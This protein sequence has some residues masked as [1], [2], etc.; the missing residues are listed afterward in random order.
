[1]KNKLFYI[2]FISFLGLQ[3]PTFAQSA[4]QTISIEPYEQYRYRNSQRGVKQDTYQTYKGDKNYVDCAFVNSE[5]KLV[6]KLL[7]SGRIYDYSKDIYGKY[8]VG[9]NMY[10]KCDKVYIRWDHGGETTGNL[11]YG[12]RSD[13]RPKFRIRVGSHDYVYQPY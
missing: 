2:S 3:L 12:E 13:G 11:N 4:Y 8:F 1:M 5:G 9:E 7:E 10:Y 6:Y